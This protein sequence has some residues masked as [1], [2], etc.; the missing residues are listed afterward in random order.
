MSNETIHE[1][2][3]FIVQ[4]KSLQITRSWYKCSC[5]FSMFEAARFIVGS[6]STVLNITDRFLPLS[7]CEISMHTCLSFPKAVVNSTSCHKDP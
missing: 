7:I 3:S 4:H 5:S 2:H 1:C 6:I